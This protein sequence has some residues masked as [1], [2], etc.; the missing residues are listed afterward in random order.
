MI[1]KDLELLAFG[2]WKNISSKLTQEWHW[3]RGLN[4]GCG[5][6]GGMGAGYDGGLRSVISD[7]VFIDCFEFFGGLGGFIGDSFGG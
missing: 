4:S 6:A 3:Q 5:R 2:M 7:F 1:F